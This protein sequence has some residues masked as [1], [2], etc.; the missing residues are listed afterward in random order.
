[1]T[2]TPNK[3]VVYFKADE[4]KRYTYGEVGL[5]FCIGKS[6]VSQIIQA[7]TRKYK[8]EIVPSHVAI[9]NGE[10][11]YESTT[12]VVNVEGTSKTIHS[13]VRRWLLSDFIKA[14]QKKE[15][16]YA[17]FPCYVNMKKLEQYVHYPYGKDTI[18]EFLFKDEAQGDS[19]GLICSQYANICTN[20]IDAPCPS[21][22]ELFRKI[23]EIR[24]LK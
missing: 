13:G 3:K 16:E 15:T 22:A 8:K 5:L 6:M 24:G 9:I 7:K 19:R 2:N 11:I 10:F 12:E 18:V 14:E 1:M 23:K 4:L 17:F 21:P 20:F